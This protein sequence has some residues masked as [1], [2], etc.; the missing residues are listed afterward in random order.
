MI[1]VELS[2]TP[3]D[4]VQA[5][6]CAH[7]I[8]QVSFVDV[9]YLHANDTMDF[10]WLWEYLNVNSQPPKTLKSDIISNRLPFFYPRQNTNCPIATPVTLIPLII[11][12]DNP[13]VG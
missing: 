13:V 2:W 3:G 6:D 9:Y 4:L 10:E 7:R 8:G 1:F 12:A 11:A 5:G